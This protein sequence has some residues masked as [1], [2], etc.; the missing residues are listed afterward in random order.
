MKK[1]LCKIFGHNWL[2]GNYK[3]IQS[4]PT[5]RACERCG[6]VQNFYGS[7]HYWE[8]TWG[9]IW[10]GNEHWRSKEEQIKYLENEANI[11]KKFKDLTT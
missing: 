3:G 2:Y 11:D 6:K 1:L 4:Q 9:Q 10:Y 8:G 5:L 7:M